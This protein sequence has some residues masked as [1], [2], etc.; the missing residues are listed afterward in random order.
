MSPNVE[1][2]RNSNYLKQEDVEPPILATIDHWEEHNM[3]QDGKPAEMKYVLLFKENCKPMSLNYTNG[4]IIKQI[5]G[6]GDLDDWAGTQIVLYKDPNISFGGKLVGGI[7]VR[8]PK[9]QAAQPV[10]DSEIPF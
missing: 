9:N 2:L 10:P 5:T 4:S 7:R 8:A 3:A 6:S 1:D